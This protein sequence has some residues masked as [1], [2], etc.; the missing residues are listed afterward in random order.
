MSEASD[1]VWSR[2]LIRLQGRFRIPVRHER[3]I[4]LYV[5]RLCTPCTPLTTP[6]WSCTPSM[7]SAEHRAWLRACTDPSQFGTE[8][9]KENYLPRLGESSF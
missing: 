2:R 7:R 4:V 9:Q 1:V 3:A 5:S 6:Q 8:A